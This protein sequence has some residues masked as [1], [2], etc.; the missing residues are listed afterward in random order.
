[1]AAGDTRIRLCGRLEVLW[2]GARVESSLRGRQGRLLFAY[3]VL[4][5]HRPV[6]RDELVAAVWP[7]E[8]AAGAE[9]SLAPLL[10]RLRRTVGTEHLEGRGELTLVLPA[11]GWVDVEALAAAVERARAAVGAGD[12]A[13]GAS[14]AGEALAIA[15]QGL[16]PGL[17]APWID[18][19]RR[20]HEEVRV[21]ILELVARA[22][23]GAGAGGA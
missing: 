4:H 16:L 13:A 23:A 20:Q 18:E 1:M 2:N 11:G 19:L 17:E 7:D 6:R 8:A 21:E 14:A 12:W 22:G 3:L 15:E 5:R 9:A 10:S